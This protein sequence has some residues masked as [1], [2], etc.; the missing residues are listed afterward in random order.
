M[1]EIAG[2][3][4]TGGASSRMGTDKARLLLQGQTFVA[5]ITQALTGVAAPLS[6]VS[7]RHSDAQAGLPVVADIH[8]G[9]GALGGLHAALTWARTPWI[10][11]VS[12]D[13]PFVTGELFTY[14][15][16]LRDEQSEAVAPVQV[17][18][19]PQP[20]CALYARRPCLH[21]A[22]RLL[23]IGDYRPR[24]LL[25]T[26][27]TRWVEPVEW[28]PL[29]NSQLFFCNVNDPDDYAHALA[30]AESRDEG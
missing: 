22:T 17:D 14:L 3:I 7:A 26:V 28:Q 16:A 29:H 25:Q 9:C 5:R 12:C 10:V 11:V 24:S 2:F 19:R 4:L 21:A 18:G 6:I 27:R 8:T 23:E 13:L 30:Q 20:L 15:A 1:S